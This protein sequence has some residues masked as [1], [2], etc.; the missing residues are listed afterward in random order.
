MHIV[1]PSHHTILLCN[2]DCSENIPSTPETIN[3][4]GKVMTRRS[5]TRHKELDFAFARRSFHLQER[6]WYIKFENLF[7][8]QKK[9]PGITGQSSK[10]KHSLVLLYVQPA[11]VVSLQ[12]QRVTLCHISSSI[13]PLQNS[14]PGCASCSVKPLDTRSFQTFT[15]VYSL[16]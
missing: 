12:T 11:D 14:P 16:P 5:G 2:I 13:L 10:P 15:R 7:E 4:P 8:G 3:L 1:L 6:E 9:H